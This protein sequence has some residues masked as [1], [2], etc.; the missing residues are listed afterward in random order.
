MGERG[1]K[2]MW[3]KTSWNRYINSA[4]V[5]DIW[6]CREDQTTIVWELKITVPLADEAGDENKIYTLQIYTSRAAAL[7]GMDQLVERLN[8]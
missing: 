1:G 3:I 2:I 5:R 4:H 8:K 7:K 6:I